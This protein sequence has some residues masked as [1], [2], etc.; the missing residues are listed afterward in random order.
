MEKE[1]HK[2]QND[3]SHKHFKK[4][5]ILKKDKDADDLI[6]VKDYQVKKLYQFPHLKH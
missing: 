1:K 2:S 4:Q 5:Y 6:K 3:S